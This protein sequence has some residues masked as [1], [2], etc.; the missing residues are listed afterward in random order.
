[1]RIPHM[2]Q[3]IKGWPDTTPEDRK[4]GADF[5]DSVE[6]IHWRL[7]HGQ[8]GRVLDLIGETLSRLNAMAETKPTTARVSAKVM[9]ALVAL[10]T[11][12]AGLADLIIDHATAW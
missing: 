1:M 9:H 6:H 4:K 3:C 10:E 12:V 5:A 7:W 2:A 8:V 11:Y